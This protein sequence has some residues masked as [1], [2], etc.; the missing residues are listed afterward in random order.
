VR[1][2]VATGAELYTDELASYIGLDKEY[3]HEFVNHTEEYVRGN[4]YTNGIDNFCRCSSEASRER[5]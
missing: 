1:E 3:I 5:I 2:H 4:V